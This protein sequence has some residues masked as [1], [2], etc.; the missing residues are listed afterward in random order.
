MYL[1]LALQQGTPQQ[2][3]VPFIWMASA[4]LFLRVPIFA[5]LGLYR[6]KLSSGVQHFSKNVFIGT[7][8]SSIAIFVLLLL[9]PANATP[10]LA[11]LIEAPLAAMFISGSRELFSSLISSRKRRNR[12]QKA[13]LIYGAG[14]V[15]AQLA[16]S[17]QTDEQREFHPIAFIDDDAS[18]QGITICGMMVLSPENAKNFAAKHNVQT[19]LLS[20]PSLR[21]WERAPVVERLQNEGFQ[22]RTV[23]SLID[24]VSG[25]KS[26]DE[27]IKITADDLLE[28]DAVPPMPHLIS[29]DVTGKVV[30]VTGAGGSIGSELCRQIA[31]SSPKALVLVEQSEHNLYEIEMELGRRFPDLQLAAILGSVCDRKRMDSVLQGY[32]IDTLYHA[33]AYK[34]VPLVEQ[35]PLEGVKNN[36]LGTLTIAEASIAAGVGKFVFISTDKAV[37]PTNVMGATKRV[38][39]EV[40]AFVAKQAS[41][42]QSP[43]IFGIVRFGNVLDSAGSVVPLFR[44]QIARGEDLT[45]THPEVTRYFMTI[46][47]AAQLVLQAGALATDG[48]V[49][50]L[51]MGESIKVM[52]LAKRMIQLHTHSSNDGAS[53]RIKI[54]GLRP[55]EKLYEEMFLDKGEA[56]PTQ[57]QKIWCATESSKDPEETASL[58]SRLQECLDNDDSLLLHEILNMYVE[59]YTPHEPAK[60]LASDASFGHSVVGV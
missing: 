2:Q 45:V 15:G 25:K 17:L 50:L 28:R 22:V 60:D 34:H 51:D 24:I 40:C 58:L 30:C 6:Q 32:G 47:E 36:V 27:V 42:H 49:F 38:A 44:S 33:A 23:P 7:T 1:A 41:A 20:I 59:G 8:V 52:D 39:E 31:F 48:E 10:Q 4:V 26:L 57:H 56:E 37:R 19:V 46:P 13:V 29:A 53:T 21:G 43:T 12:A 5:W 14:N 11:L 16:V 35:N 3:L 54:T 18:K 9:S 55:G